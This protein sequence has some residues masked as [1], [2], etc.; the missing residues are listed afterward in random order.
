[1]YDKKLL[2]T[3]VAG[4]L[5]LLTTSIP[6]LINQYSGTSPYYWNL[7]LILDT[8]GWAGLVLL[9]AALLTLTGSKYSNHLLIGGLFIYLAL[10]TGVL[11]ALSSLL[12]ITSAYLLGRG[13]FHLTSN[14][15]DHKTYYYRATLVGI[16]LYVALFS[17]LIHFPIN[18]RSLYLA[19]VVLPFCTLTLRSFRETLWLALTSKAQRSSQALQAISFRSV[20]ASTFIIGYILRFAFFP[21]IGSDDNVMHL[22]MWTELTNTLHYSFNVENQIWSVAPFAY[23]LLHAILS[24]ISNADARGSLNLIVLTL[25]LYALWAISA[26]TLKSNADRLL[27]IL[28]FCSTPIIAPLLIYLQT[29]LFLAF[30]VTSAVRILLE[31]EENA[32][33]SKLIS[34]LAVAALCAATKLP[35]MVLGAIVLTAYLPALIKDRNLLLKGKNTYKTLAFLA[36]VALFSFVA[37]QSYA[38]SW[39]R[40]GNPLFPLYNGIFKSPYYSL[41][42]FSDPL[43]QKGFTL[44]SFWSLFYN[45]GAHYEANN[46]TSGFQYLYLFPL[47]LIAL[48]ASKATSRVIKFLLVLPVFGFGLAMFSATQYWRYLFPILP[49]ASIIIGYLLVNPKN[50][51][52]TP[53]IGHKVTQTVFVFLI[54]VNIY[55]LPGIAWFLTTPAQDAFTN[56][57]KTSISE[58]LA[59]SRAITAYL[60]A[61]THNPVVLY[62]VSASYGATLLG[63]PIYTSWYSPAK[64]WA[65][66]SVKTKDEIAL[67]IDQWK[68]EYVVWNSSFATSIASRQAMLGYLTEHGQPIYQMGSVFLYKLSKE[69][70]DY[71]LVY[72]LQQQT[73]SN[74]IMTETQNFVADTTPR[75]ISTIDSQN[76]KSAKYDVTF[77]CSSNSGS[78]IAQIN[79]NVPPVYYKLIPCNEGR[80]RFTETLPIPVGATSGDVYITARDRDNVEVI[81]LTVGVAHP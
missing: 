81:S 10:G 39:L 51:D 14:N 75:V 77:E 36:L 16:A 30:L 7:P 15:D 45:S 63:Q 6:L 27:V 40:T 21:T 70:I 71:Q 33:V 42:N 12:F 9:L 13:V 50:I 66:G 78:F 67:L 19:I 55:F 61:T 72:S 53:E 65:F 37:L 34:V 24:I 58:S 49:L 11:S 25:L 28:L 1:M 44:Q 4:L 76:S 32:A 69:K 47:G 80:T 5:L 64:S 18:T 74:L 57:G 20:V 60:N 73:D 3:L 38:Y 35:G 8:L 79:W 31:R 54:G 59:P 22:R 62:D 68:I 56:N 43:Y 41:D 23:D 48:I 46:F 2:P 52:G 26:S 17:I 29:E